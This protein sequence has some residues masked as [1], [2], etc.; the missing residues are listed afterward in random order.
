MDANNQ[1]S[2]KNSISKSPISNGWFGLG[3][4][5]GIQ[6]ALWSSSVTLRRQEKQGDKWITTEELHVAP[7]VLKEIAWRCG[8]WLSVIEN[9]RNESRSENAN[10][11]RGENE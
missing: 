10:K 9:S 1:N 3:E 11:R 2:N 8:H 7:S 5:R 4:G 6:W